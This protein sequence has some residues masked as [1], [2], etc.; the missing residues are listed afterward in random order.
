MANQIFSPDFFVNEIV[1]VQFG[2][3]S[4]HFDYDLLDIEF[5]ESLGLL[6]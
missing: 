6:S 2:H 3:Y 4:N 5:F 1:F